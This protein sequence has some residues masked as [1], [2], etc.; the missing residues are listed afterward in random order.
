[1]PIPAESGA[2]EK[3]T[4]LNVGAFIVGDAG[5]GCAWMD[6]LAKL[7]FFMKSVLWYMRWL[8]FY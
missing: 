6:V 5:V 8:F 1:V 2:F 3:H 7:D 4:D